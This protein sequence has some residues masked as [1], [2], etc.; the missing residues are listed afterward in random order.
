LALVT[1]FGV[2]L[3]VQMPPAMVTF[4]AAL[5]PV[6]GASVVL[7]SLAEYR[8]FVW[9]GASAAIAILLVFV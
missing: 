5:V 1:V 6:L 4:F 9:T 3:F 2:D 8:F 7:S